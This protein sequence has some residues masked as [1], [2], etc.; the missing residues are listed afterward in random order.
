MV[1]SYIGVDRQLKT[2]M[3]IC[4]S[5]ILGLGGPMKTIC[6]LMHPWHAEQ[7]AG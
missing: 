5:D 6:E 4:M 7:P 1:Y 2:H 3:Y